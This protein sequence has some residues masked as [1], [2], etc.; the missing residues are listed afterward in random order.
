MSSPSA[1]AITSARHVAI[2]RT[3]D[4]EPVTKRRRYVWFLASAGIGLDGYDL[5]IM[6]AAGPLIVADLGLDT[7]QKSIAVGAAVLGAVPGAL[8]GGRLADRIGRQRMLK[9]DLF[10]FVVT[11][12]LSAFAWNVASLA[13]FR[14]LQGAAVGAEYPLSASMV[15]EVMP[16]RSRGRWMTGAFSFQ[17]VGMVAASAVATALLLAPAVMKSVLGLYVVYAGMRSSRIMLAAVSYALAS[18]ATVI[19]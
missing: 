17:A 19:V 16:A 12:V 14:F 5:F 4:D 7:W 10:V 11:A 13:V 6:S 18:L 2:G 8:L 3:L 1:G 9:I 15:S